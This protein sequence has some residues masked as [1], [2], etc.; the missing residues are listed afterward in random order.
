VAQTFQAIRTGQ[1]TSVSVLLMENDAG[2]DFDVEIWTATENH[3]PSVFLTGTVVTDV[4]ATT[5][6]AQRLLTATFA[7]PAPVV[8][9][10]RYALVITKG[11]NAF[12]AIAFDN[13]CA[14][15]MFLSTGA[16]G[17]PF[18]HSPSVDLHYETVV[19]A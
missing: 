13:P 5:F 6:P 15:G 1:L 9:G 14:D 16:L 17:T 4:P 11:D 18:V 2:M 12:F 8:S 10:T 19:L 3:I 7:N